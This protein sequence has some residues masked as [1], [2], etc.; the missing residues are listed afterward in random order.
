MELDCV[1]AKS[2]L[3]WN[4]IWNL[5]SALE[6]TVEW[7]KA[8]YNHDAMINTTIRQIHEYEELVKKGTNQQ[9]EL[10]IL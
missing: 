1:K 7:Y 4:P 3:G 9:N 8:Y 10:Q 6:K 5:N 2:K